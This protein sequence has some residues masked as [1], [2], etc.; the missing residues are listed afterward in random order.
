M[1]NWLHPRNPDWTPCLDWTPF[2]G[3]RIE[4]HVQIE[5][6]FQEPRLNTMSRCLW[7]CFQ[8]RLASIIFLIYYILFSCCNQFFL[9]YL[10]FTGIIYY[11][12]TDVK[13]S[14]ASLIFCSP[15][16]KPHSLLVLYVVPWKSIPLSWKY[17]FTGVHPS[18]EFSRIIQSR[19]LVISM[20]YQYIN[21][22]L[23]SLEEYV[24]IISFNI[25]YIP[26]IV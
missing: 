9:Q 8:R 16:P 15:S 18:V 26:C 3:T 6:H 7:G 22:I 14:K 19:S 24:V 13:K 4:H 17:I 12:E 11:M 10:V 1:S 25:F 20:P 5:H 2:P 21:L 23:P